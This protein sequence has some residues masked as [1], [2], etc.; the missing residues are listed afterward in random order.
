[1][2][3][4]Y[5]LQSQVTAT[6]YIGTTND[7]KRRIKE[8]NSGES[9]YTKKYMPWEVIYYEAYTNKQDA[10]RREKYFKTT[11]GHLAIKR[12]LKEYFNTFDEKH[13]SYQGSTT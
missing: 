4:T 5:L 9:A 11:Q 7:L 8:H 10:S 2:F 6:L 12:M 1:M 3:Y 13:F